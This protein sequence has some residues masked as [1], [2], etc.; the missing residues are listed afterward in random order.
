MNGKMK[1]STWNAMLSLW[2]HR[3]GAWLGMR[4]LFNERDQYQTLNADGYIHPEFKGLGIGTSLLRAVEVRA[5]EE[6]KLAEPDLRVF[7]RSTIDN[8]DEQGHT[9]HKTEG[10]FSI[11]YH[12]RMEIKLQEA[13][14]AVTFPD[15]IELRPFVKDEHAVAVWQADNEAFRDH[16]GSHDATFE[17]WSHRKFEQV[18]F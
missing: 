7:I 16:W 2:K 11:R 8:K 14:P 6:M 13:P 5:R 15:G 12:W 4:N 17:D 3:M 18:R 1:V 9:V 10:Y